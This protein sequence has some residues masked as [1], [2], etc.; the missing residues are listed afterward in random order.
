MLTVLVVD[1]ALLPWTGANVWTAAVAIAV[2]G[3]CGWGLLVP[4]Q[5]RLVTLAPSIAPVL[6]GLN[7]AA[8]Y[9]GVSVAGLIGA[10]T[11]QLLGVGDVGFVAAM[12]LAASLIV[13]EFATRRI[14]VVADH[15]ARPARVPA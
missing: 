15:A 13:S 8:T 14:A 6:L 1:I 11:I 5:H 4:Q 2:W 9:I 7:T 10:G 12:L 3:G